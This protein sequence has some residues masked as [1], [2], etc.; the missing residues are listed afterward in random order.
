MTAGSW[1]PMGT[2]TRVVTAVRQLVREPAV[3]LELAERGLAQAARFRWEDT[4]G[5]HVE[6]LCSVA[7]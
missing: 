5:A 7:R 1:Y 4:I 2:S 6:L 3:R